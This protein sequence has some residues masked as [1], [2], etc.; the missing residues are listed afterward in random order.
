MRNGKNDIQQVFLAL[1]RGGLW[2]KEVRLS[3]FGDVDY[4]EVMSLAEEQSVVGLVTAEGGVAAVCRAVVTDRAAQ[5][6]DECFC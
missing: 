5:Q 3:Q 4:E 6:S 1:V 2:E